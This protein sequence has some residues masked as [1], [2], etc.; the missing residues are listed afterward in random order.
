MSSDIA[1]I[2][3]VL[4]SQPQLSTGTVAPPHPVQGSGVE[5]RASG[6]HQPLSAPVPVDED[7][8]NQRPPE[9]STQLGDPRWR[10]SQS[11]PPAGAQVC[12]DVLE[13][14]RVE[15]A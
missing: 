3:D 8:T 1:L 15:R 10:Q 4:R 5:A 14:F 9:G 13:S 12:K 6:E 7:T 11:G 2:L